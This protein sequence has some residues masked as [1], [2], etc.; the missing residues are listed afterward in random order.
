MPSRVAAS[1]WA[2]RPSFRRWGA[3]DS[4]RPSS[5]ATSGSSPASR[6]KRPAQCAA[7]R[8]VTL[9]H[10]Q[11]P[12]DPPSGRLHPPERMVGLDRHRRPR[13]LGGDGGVAVTIAPHPGAPSEER[14]ER[15][16]PRSTAFG[17]EGA[18]HRAIDRRQGH[19]DRLVEQ[20]ERRSHLIERF[21]TMPADG[22]RTPQ[23][24][25]LLAQPTMDLLLIGGSC[26]QVLELFEQGADPPQVLDHGATLGLG[27]VGGQ[28]RGDAQILERGRIHVQGVDRVLHRLARTGATR[29]DAQT[30]ALFGQV[31]QLEVAGERADH[32][33]GARD[34]ELIHEGDDRG[35][36]SRSG[37]APERDRREAERLHLGEQRRARRSRRSR[38]RASW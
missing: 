16:P 9:R 23:P 32:V 26:G 19:E 30:L 7:R 31:H 37:R 12:R 5:V 21:G 22:L 13:D 1:R 8:H 20:G 36:A 11:R 15:G 29:Q 6:S 4:V 34:I 10:R 35:P 27:G 33:F 38:R 2:A 17:V 18:V 3:S 14:R 24:G 28:H 25:D